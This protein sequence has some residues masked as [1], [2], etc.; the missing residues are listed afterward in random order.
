MPR[1]LICL[2]FGVPAGRGGSIG[3]QAGY[4][5]LGVVEDTQFMGDRHSAEFG[6]VGQFGA[7]RA[8]KQ[9]G[10]T[11]DQDTQLKC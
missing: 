5:P 9:G 1:R 2:P 4:L 3:S 6:G 7:H 11:G 10:G 8:G